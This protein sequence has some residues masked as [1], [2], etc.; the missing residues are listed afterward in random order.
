MKIIKRVEREEGKGNYQLVYFYY[1]LSM[2][3][4]EILAIV[5]KNKNKKIKL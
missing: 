4:L 5:K 2:K 1:V 3:I